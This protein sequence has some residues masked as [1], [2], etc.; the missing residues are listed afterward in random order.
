[1]P[2]TLVTLSLP[3][4]RVHHG[5]PALVRDLLVM[6]G[7]LEQGHF[8][9]L[10]GQH[11]DTFLRFSS[12]ARDRAKLDCFGDWLVP[13]VAPWQADVVFAP[14]TAGVAL[15]WVLARR[16]GLPLEL[17]E[18]N[19]VG[20]AVGLIGDVHLADRRVLLVNDVVTTGGGMSALAD[21]AEAG[22]GE[23]AGAAWF[24][25]RAPVD[26]AALIDAPVAAVVDL[27]LAATDADACSLCDDGIPAV[28]GRDLN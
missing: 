16:L 15:G 9:L 5:D 23:V 17:A 25:S 7:A 2:E 14:S 11:T 3:T 13:S 24:A 6:P 20:R 4:L 10:S 22:G 21:V 18:L 26:V 8:V 12:L 19:E 28:P 1:M 27:E